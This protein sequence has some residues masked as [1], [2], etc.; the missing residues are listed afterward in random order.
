MDCEQAHLE[1]LDF[2]LC[3]EQVEVEVLHV[4]HVCVA[5]VDPR[6]IVHARRAFR[7]HSIQSSSHQ[8]VVSGGPPRRRNDNQRT[9]SSLLTR[10][11]S[12]ARSP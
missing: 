1:S 11:A 7:T 8:N 9:D 6:V 12:K 10:E 4:L 2:I 3:P 5:R